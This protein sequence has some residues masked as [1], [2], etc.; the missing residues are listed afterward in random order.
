M[1][2]TILEFPARRAIRFPEDI[3]ATLPL[4]EYVAKVAANAINW[5]VKGELSAAAVY[6]EAASAALQR[7]TLAGSPAIAARAAKAVWSKE[8]MERVAAGVAKRR[9]TMR[10]K[11]ERREAA[12]A[13]TPPPSA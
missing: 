7:A 5:M 3:E 11:R 2:A 13:E 10:L 12:A 1:S 8:K 4:A 6:F 9:E